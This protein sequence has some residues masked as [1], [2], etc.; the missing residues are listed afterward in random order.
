[1]SR[2]T[3]FTGLL[4]AVVVLIMA[5]LVLK[6]YLYPTP[7]VQSSVISIPEIEEDY[8][9]S[10]VSKQ[11]QDSEPELSQDIPEEN[12]QQD[13]SNDTTIGIALPGKFLNET[14]LTNSGFSSIVQ[15]AVSLKI[16]Q[17][18]D[19]GNYAP[20]SI[21]SYQVDEGSNASGLFTEWEYADEISAQEAM[22]VIRNKSKV[23]VDLSVNATNNYG[24]GSF[25]INHAKKPDEA[26]LVI[27]MRN[28]LYTFA[29]LKI[30][31]PQVKA[32]ISN[33]YTAILDR[34][35]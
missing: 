29:Y 10:E 4:A 11:A 27:R 31:H 24:D 18:F 23:Y 30:Y 17:L 3:F 9:A 1:M 16:F 34:P 32:L 7:Q 5:Q 26:F 33:L 28:F 14:T 8:L 6:D 2:F 13:F 35:I 19:M 22:D 25:F 15:M 12:V 20:S 21:A